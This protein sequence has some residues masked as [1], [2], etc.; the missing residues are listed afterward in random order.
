MIQAHPF[1]KVCPASVHGSS[2]GA[3]TAQHP[4]LLVRKAT[5]SSAPIC[6]LNVLPYCISVS[7]PK[8]PPSAACCNRGVELEMGFKG[9]PCP[10]Y[11]L[12]TIPWEDALL[13]KKPGMALLL[14]PYETGLRPRPRQRRG[15]R[16]SPPGPGPACCTTNSARLGWGFP[17]QEA[18][19]ASTAPV[20]PSSV[21][22]W[23]LGTHSCTLPLPACPACSCFCL[24]PS[25]RDPQ[26][27]CPFLPPRRDLGQGKPQDLR[28]E[29]V[30]DVSSA[31]PCLQL[32]SVRWVGAF[33]SPQEYFLF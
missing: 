5:P 29:L 12:K 31:C 23:D 32:L 33:W 10:K 28:N 18:P 24:R 30:R 27:W 3:Q 19:Q 22:G 7:L 16:L 1:P 20:V 14:E 21:P 6:L 11:I 17:W 13:E 4:A 9:L 25:G 15:C 2:G 26:P 8:Q